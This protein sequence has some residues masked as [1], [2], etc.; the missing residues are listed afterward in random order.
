MWCSVKPEG[1]ML[2]SAVRRAPGRYVQVLSL[3]VRRRGGLGAAHDRGPYNSIAP[4]ISFT[5]H[6]CSL[7][8]SS[9]PWNN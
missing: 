8:T 2:V 6:I 1:G 3:H 4:I 7:Y 9:C 5:V